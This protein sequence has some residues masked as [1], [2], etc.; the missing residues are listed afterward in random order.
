MNAKEIYLDGVSGDALSHIIEY[1][2]S[3]KLTLD[4][5]NVQDI[6]AAAHY[7]QL[8]DVVAMCEKF[9]LQ[10]LDVSNALDL[11]D[12]ADFYS[13]N[14]LRRWAERLVN[15][16]FMTILDSESFLR[17]TAEQLFKLLSRT[18]IVVD[19]EQHIF[20]AIVK[21]ISSG[22]ERAAAYPMLMKAIRLLKI[23]DQVK[24]ATINFD[25]MRGYSLSLQMESAFMDM[26]ARKYQQDGKVPDELRCYGIGIEELF[27]V[28][29]FCG[30]NQVVINLYSYAEQ[31]LDVLQIIHDADEPQIHRINDYLYCVSINLQDKTL[32]VSHNN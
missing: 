16:K 30:L 23:N 4:A 20:E 27:L 8:E 5:T 15:F 10:N 2:Y 14:V 26:Y 3:M 11:F 24:F 22:N 9:C 29:D 32:Q 28:G 12:Y 18:K 17:L 1:C 21:W 31:T 19:S 7:F 25:A 6:L 13:L